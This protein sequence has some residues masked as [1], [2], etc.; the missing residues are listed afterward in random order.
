MKNFRGAV[1][2]LGHQNIKFI[3]ENFGGECFFNGSTQKSKK[4]KKQGL[5]L[6]LERPDGVS[7]KNRNDYSSK[8]LGEG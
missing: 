6:P 5:E 4:K 1:F 8:D 3:N 7:G 2:L